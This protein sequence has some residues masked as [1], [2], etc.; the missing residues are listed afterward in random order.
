MSELLISSLSPQEQELAEHAIKASITGHAPISQFTVGGALLLQEQDNNSQYHIVQGHNYELENVNSICAERHCLQNACLQYNHI[1]ASNYKAIAIYAPQS[2]DYIMPCGFCRQALFE[3]NPDI[4]IIS[5]SPDKQHYKKFSIRELLP[6]AF[7]LN[8]KPQASIN[9]KNSHLLQYIAHYPVDYNRL[10]HLK[11]ITKLLAVGSPIRARKLAKYIS[12]KYKTTMHEYCHIVSGNTDREYTLYSIPEHGIAIAS[13]GIGCSGVEIM[14]SEIE[15]LIALANNQDPAD[16]IQNLKYVIRSGTRGTLGDIPLGSV[17]LSSS[18]V[19]LN[20]NIL[21]Q[22]VL[23]SSNIYSVLKDIAYNTAPDKVFEGKCLSADF[24]YEQQGRHAYPLRKQGF[25]NT[26]YLQTLLD[27]N[28]TWLEMEDYYI[29]YF[30]QK[31]N[32]QTASIGLVMA[33]RYNFE[34]KEFVL[35]YNANIKSSF[36]LV[37]AEIAYETLLTIK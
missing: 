2:A 4:E 32:M 31:Y 30:G 18:T 12:T 21:S 35:D 8:A 9:T 23:P 1:P 20:N 25:A 37:P 19:C 27:N 3:S 6:H 11:S 22:E 7:E 14:L 5:I 28:I 36:E 24:F 17:A 29:N 26:E 33:R 10:T 13:H 16:N 34:T 15:A